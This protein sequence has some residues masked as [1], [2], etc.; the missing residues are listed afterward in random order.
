MDP[1]IPQSDDSPASMPQ[2]RIGVWGGLGYM[3]LGQPSPVPVSP[4]RTSPTLAKLATALAKAQGE[5]PIAGKRSD[6]PF[7]RSRYAD[8]ASI[9]EAIREPLSKYGISFMQ[10]PSI[11][12]EGQ[13]EFEQ[14]TT[15]SGDVRLVVK[16]M[17]KVTVVTRIM[18]EDE[19]V[20]SELFALIPTADPQSIGSAETYLRRYGLAPMVGVVAGDD[21]DDGNA[22]SPP[23]PSRPVAAPVEPDGYQDWLTDLYAVADNG[24]LALENA[25]RQ[26]QPYLRKHLTDTNPALWETIK[27]RA[28]ALGGKQKGSEPS[29]KGSAR[30]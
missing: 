20:E 19:W 25:W 30:A 21:D 4:I 6:N 26:S 22:A 1:I 17:T 14:R 23:A 24:T 28:A 8:L 15:K 9:R 12:V 2:R 16:A 27:G 18:F 7:F 10:M 5:M 3:P 29:T 11:Q 13:P